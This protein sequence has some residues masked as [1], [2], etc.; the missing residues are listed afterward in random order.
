MSSSCPKVK[1]SS[2]T[3][4]TQSRWTASSTPKRWTC[5]SI[6]SSGTRVNSSSSS[7]NIR[8]MKEDGKEVKYEREKAAGK[9][10]KEEER[11]GL[12]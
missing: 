1:R 7:S 11:G 9:E 5:S 6:T 10:K 2:D 4:V 12:E 8:Q 3:L